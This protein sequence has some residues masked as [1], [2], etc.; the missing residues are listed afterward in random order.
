MVGGRTAG[1]RAS[2]WGRGC[3]PPGPLPTSRLPAVRRR[4]AARALQAGC[5][6]ASAAALADWLACVGAASLCSAARLALL[7]LPPSSPV[8]YTRL[9]ACMTPPPHLRNST[10]IRDLNWVHTSDC[11]RPHIG[12]KLDWSTGADKE[13]LHLAASADGLYEYICGC[14]GCQPWSRGEPA[15]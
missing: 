7:Q 12:C 2:K 8:W 15:G 13:G 11:I 3:V 4:S 6:A 9:A 14:S 5:P 1:R 10:T